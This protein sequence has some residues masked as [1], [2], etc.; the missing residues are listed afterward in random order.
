MDIILHHYEASPYSEKMR[1]YLGYKGVA[2]RSMIVPAIAPKPDLTRLTA[3][4]RRTPVLQIG[5]DIYCDTSLMIDRLEALLPGPTLALGPQAQA[6]ALTGLW[7]EVDLFWRAARLVLASRA[8]QLPDAF[9]ADRGAM[10]GVTLDRVQMQAALPQLAAAMAALLPR[11]EACLAQA[12]AFLGGDTPSVADFQLYHPLW[13]LGSVNGFARFG[14]RPGAVTAW[15]GRMAG[16]GHGV[17]TPIDAADTFVQ[18]GAQPPTDLPVH[19]E[20]PGVPPL[21]TSLSVA[22]ESFGKEASIGTLVAL[23]GARIAL[24]H[25]AAGIGPVR[26][27]FPRPGYV[28]R[29]AARPGR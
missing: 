7:A 16:F 14:L 23:N 11:I 9:L 18:A 24:D 26:V 17:A 29:P 28:L 12:G 2:W 4:Y 10:M 3:G 20:G 21:G 5:A 1:A 27:H 8:D 13:F 6:Q 25:D 22:P 19:Q 15:L